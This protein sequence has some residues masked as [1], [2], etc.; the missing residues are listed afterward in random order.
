MIFRVALLGV[1][2]HCKM[3]LSPR[4]YAWLI[5]TCDYSVT[6]LFKP[7]IFRNINSYGFWDIAWDEQVVYSHFLL[8]WPYLQAT[9]MFSGVSVRMDKCLLLHLLQLIFIFHSNPF[10]VKRV[11]ITNDLLK[12]DVPLSKLSL[13]MLNKLNASHFPFSLSFPAIILVTPGLAYSCLLL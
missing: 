12:M 4:V 3:L 6:K 10:P 1:I 8:L 13:L 11:P 5:G 2:K 7:S 9:F